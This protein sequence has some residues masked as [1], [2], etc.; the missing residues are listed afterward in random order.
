MRIV[1]IEFNEITVVDKSCLE[2]IIIFIVDITVN[3]TFLN[4]IIIIA[5][6]N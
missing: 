1:R 3:I 2:Y 4:T 6:K 5:K